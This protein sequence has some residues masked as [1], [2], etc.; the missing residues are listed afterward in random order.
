MIELGI[1]FTDYEYLVDE[2]NHRVVAFGWWAGAVGVYNTIRGWGLKYKSFNL[3][4]PHRGTTLDK[5]IYDLNNIKLPAIKIIVTGKGRVSKGAQYVLDRIGIERVDANDF[6]SNETYNA[7]YTLLCLEELVKHKN[8]ECDFN[9]GDFKN[10]PQNYESNF[11]T[12]ATKCDMLITCHF[13]GENDPIY[14]DYEDL[15]RSDLRIKVIGDVTCDIKGSI[16]STIRSSTHAIPFYDYNKKT[17]KEEAPFNSESNIT[18]MAVDTLP[19]A[20]PTDTSKSFGE[21]LIKNIIPLIKEGINS[22]MID[23]ATI[24]KNGVITEK[25]NYLIEF[26]KKQ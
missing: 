13:W 11:M 9:R 19:N 10:N 16:K 8:N 7:S 22:P 12:Y 5:M 2:N 1:T 15:K 20:L 3:E 24:L 23:R 6:I 14:L 4:K 26:T 25:Y 17:Q 18:V 21:Q